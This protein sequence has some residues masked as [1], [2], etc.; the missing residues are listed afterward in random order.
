M[1]IGSRF[2]YTATRGIQNFKNIHVPSFSLV[3]EANLIN[4]ASF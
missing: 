4:Q 3:S 2:L 1:I